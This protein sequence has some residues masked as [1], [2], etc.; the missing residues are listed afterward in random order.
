[1]R[2]KEFAEV[3][4][5]DMLQML[6]GDN[7]NHTSLQQ[8]LENFR[9]QYWELVK[10]HLPKVKRKLITSIPIVARKKA[11]DTKGTMSER[12]LELMANIFAFWTLSDLRQFDKLTLNDLSFLI[13]PHAGQIL[14][15]LRLLGFDCGVN[16]LVNPL[17][18]SKL[19]LHNH[20]I[21]LG[22]GEGKSVVLAVLAVILAVFGYDVDC[23]C[24]SDYLQQRD[25]NE[26]RKLFE[27]FEVHESITY[28]TFNDI[29]KIFLNANGDIKQIVEQIV[30]N[31][32][33]AL[34]NSIAKKKKQKQRIFLIDEADVF[35]N[36]AFYGNIY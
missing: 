13:Q 33:T 31:N 21:E 9:H 22:T 6:S 36:T 10:H 12:V 15:L 16:K 3:S 28:G 24:F 18:Q 29:C 5:M 8:Y 7:V 1:M 26:F 35:L 32:F 30:V 2:N 11:L 17:V 27:A 34:T 4:D 19:A 23:A 14:S 25:K 20:L